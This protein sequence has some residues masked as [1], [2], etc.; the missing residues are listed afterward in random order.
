[1]ISIVCSR[2]CDENHTFCYFDMN[3]IY[4]S[5]DN[6]TFSLHLYEL[7]PPLCFS[8]SF[9]H[10]SVHSQVGYIRKGLLVMPPNV[11]IN[12]G[13]TSTRKLSSRKP[14]MSISSFISSLRSIGT[15]GNSF[16]LSLKSARSSK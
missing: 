10:L 7:H 4:D 9:D 12:L 16:S 2:D 15:R 5:T 14:N 6:N 8:H 1:M 11:L 3:E 13:S